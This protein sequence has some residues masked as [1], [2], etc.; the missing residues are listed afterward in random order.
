MTKLYRRL[1]GWYP[2][3]FLAVELQSALVIVAGTLALFTFYFEGDWGEYAA[4]LA[5]ALVLTEAAIVATLVRIQPL[6]RPLRRWIDGERDQESTDR[7]WSAAVSLPLHLVKRDLPMPVLV[8]VIPTCVAGIV[9]LDLG[10]LTIIPLLLGAAIAMGYSAMLHYLAV[11]AGMRPLLLDINA[12]LSP[13]MSAAGFWAV[14]LRT[15]LV[16]ALPLI[17]LI[18][19]L[20]VAALTSG[21]GGGAALGLDVLVVLLVATTISLELTM[22]LSRS[23]L[24]PL[25]DLERGLE[26]V[27]AGQY[28]VSVPVTTGDEL[29]DLA[30]T[31]N[32]MVEG[33]A[34]RE[35]IREA[36]GTYLDEEVA[37][38][39]LS[40]GFTEEGVEVEVTVLFCDVRDFTEFASRATPQQVVT[41]LNR[42]FE[43]IVPIIARHG[44]HV[45]KFEGDGLLAVFGAPEPFP[46]HADR[47]VSAAC[48]IG[49][50]INER[51]QAGDLRLG[52]GV[53]TGT[54]I[55][56][57][58]GGAGRLNFSVIGGAVNVAARVE[59]RTR[60]TDDNILITVDTWTRLSHKFEAESRGR[61]ELRGVSEPV[62]L[63]AP[64]VAGQE[65]VPVEREPV[66]ARGDG[67]GDGEGLAEA[68]RRRLTRPPRLRR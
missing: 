19:G 30:A 6:L 63:Y 39:I 32:Q 12:N 58:I 9:I 33:L 13:R 50:A 20:I 10:W 14:P 65:E 56:G 45:D 31:F 43:V 68:L 15:R 21:G 54:V 22:L 57:A 27:R 26:R 46:D 2:F 23:I 66:G 16:V 67:A 18:T 44:G 62:A 36:F 24:S 7:A 5:I 47:A 34:E 41:A 55:A 11:E 60:E 17:N 25:K 52:V 48:E 37:E 8:T 42:L 4:V 40:E 35:R 3:A 51:G 59:A 38:Y 1:G 49:V 29:G 64:K 53:N 61:V 28:D